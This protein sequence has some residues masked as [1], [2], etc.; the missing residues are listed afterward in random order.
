[1]SGVLQTFIEPNLSFFAAEVVHV[2]KLDDILLRPAHS[3]LRA[4][5]GSCRPWALAQVA[6]GAALVAAGLG[7]RGE[8]PAGSEVAACLL[9]LGAGVVITWASRLLVA[10]LAFLA[11]C[12]EPGVLYGTFW[13]LGRY[14][15]GIYHPAIQRIATYVVPVAFIAT[16]PAQALLRG[17]GPL[18]LL[19][20]PATALGAGLITSLVWSAGIRRYTS[21]TN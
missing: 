21:V 14:P 8:V 2:G 10:S 12:V 15:V 1:M 3:A 9:L 5:L 20:G 16:V 19:A 18:L 7:Q 17:V 4:S 11:P 13:Q 6:V